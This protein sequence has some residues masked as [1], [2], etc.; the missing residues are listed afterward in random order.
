MKPI[1]FIFL[2]LS[3]TLACAWSLIVINSYQVYEQT[4]S[5]LVFVLAFASI[6]GMMIFGYKTYLVR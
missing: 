2:F 5:G 4:P 6:A 1:L 3:C